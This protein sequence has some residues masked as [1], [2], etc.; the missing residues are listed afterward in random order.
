[1]TAHLRIAEF[2]LEE[3]STPE[4]LEARLHLADCSDCRGQVEQF[5]SICAML[6]TSA[7]VEPPRR[8]MFEFE[9][10]LA[11]SW[12]W[13]WLAPMG[14]S[15]AIALAVVT[16]AP[17]PQPQ[18]VERVVQQQVAAQ[19]R[20]LAAEAVDYQKIRELLTT[21]LDK[22]D[23][24]HAKEILRLRGDLALMDSYQRA[25]ERETIDNGSSIQ[26]LAQK[27]EYTR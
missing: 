9:K 26:L 19:P 18:I 23:A 13:R 11:F 8:I 20:P 15:A 25:T 16:L 1:M 6:R 2:V 21:E 10:P 27:T 24:T 4:M 17:R 5:Q 3:L 7:D 14:A 12:M 22:R